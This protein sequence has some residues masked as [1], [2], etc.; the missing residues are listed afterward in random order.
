M[1]TLL[2]TKVYDCL[3]LSRVNRDGGA[4]NK[5][6]AKESPAMG[7]RWSQSWSGSAGNLKESSPRHW[8]WRTSIASCKSWMSGLWNT[9]YTYT[10]KLPDLIKVSHLCTESESM[11][12]AAL[13]LNL[14]T[15]LGLQLLRSSA[16][17]YPD[18]FLSVLEHLSQC[19]SSSNHNKR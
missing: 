1:S 19:R 13:L 3:I 18:Q 2:A 7:W 5:P 11:H 16:L 17:L 8:C 9:L 4:D 14:F 6:P 15:F 12:L 10:V